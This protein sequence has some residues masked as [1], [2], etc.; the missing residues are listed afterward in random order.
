MR[1]CGEGKNVPLRTATDLL[2][3]SQLLYRLSHISKGFSERK[4]YH[5][6]PLA[7]IPKITLCPRENRQIPLAIDGRVRYDGEKEQAAA[8]AP[9]SP[10]SNFEL[11]QPPIF[12]ERE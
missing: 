4:V 1:S 11:R 2:I 10:D 5:I 8:S 12:Y 9:F 6:F 3:T 7:S